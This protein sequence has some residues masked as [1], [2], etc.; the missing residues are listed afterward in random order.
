[1]DEFLVKVASILEV[2]SVSADADF[3]AVEGWCSLKAFGLLV[4]LDQEYGRT[5]SIDD[6]LDLHTVADLAAAAGIQGIWNTESRKGT[7]DRDG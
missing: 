4:M 3:R 6:F 5:L 7:N 1:M 2:P